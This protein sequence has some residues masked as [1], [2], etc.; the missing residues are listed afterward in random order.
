[1]LNPKLTWSLG[2][3]VSPQ[4]TTDVVVNHNLQK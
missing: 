3:F 4:L 1:M 2:A